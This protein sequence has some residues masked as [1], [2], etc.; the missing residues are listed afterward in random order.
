MKNRIMQIVE[1]SAKAHVSDLGEKAETKRKIDVYQPGDTVDVH[2]RIL[3]G[4]KERIQV[5]SGLVVSKHGS[6]MNEM[7][8]VR[9][10][11]QSEGVERTFPVIS[12]R[13]A[14]IE[15]KKTGKVR[16]AKLYYMRDRVG[17]ATRLKERVSKTAPK[18]PKAA[19]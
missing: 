17:K 9:K 8:T 15:V 1:N 18:A 4:E 7:V 16:R 10:I 19:K 13:V 6:G 14:R 2:I 12:P 11:V 3:D 5:F